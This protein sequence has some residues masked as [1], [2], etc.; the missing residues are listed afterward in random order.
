MEIVEYFS[1]SRKRHWLEELKKS[2][3]SA[4]KFLVTLLTENTF[5]SVLGKSGKLYFM[6]DEDKIV[7]FVTLTQRDCIADDTLFPW[8]GFLFTFPEYRGHRY[9]EAIINYAVEKA[10]EQGYD[11]VYL[12][13]D[14]VG[15]YEKYGFVYKENRVDVWGEDSRI[16]VRG[17]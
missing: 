11:K 15:L 10:R 1:D 7:S 14:H 17:F 9:S 3:W 2:N 5:D 13:T 8:L 4:A 16:Y 6:I 12:A